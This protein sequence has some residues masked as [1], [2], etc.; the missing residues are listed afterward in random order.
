MRAQPVRNSRHHAKRVDAS[1][2]GVSDRGSTPLAST[3]SKSPVSSSKSARYGI[4]MIKE[5]LKKLRKLSIWVS[6]REE[7]EIKADSFKAAEVGIKGRKR[8][9]GADGE[10]GEVGVHP[11]LWRGRW[12]GGEFE[13]EFAGAFGFGIESA[14]VGLGTPV[15]EDGGSFVVG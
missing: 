9:T 10:G 1:V 2:D 8:E 7:K 15:S 13:P 6:G 12:D 3:I 14:D 5:H 11:D 4:F